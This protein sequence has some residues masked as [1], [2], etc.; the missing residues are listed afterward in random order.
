M[1]VIGAP[2]GGMAAGVAVPTLAK[3]KSEKHG[4]CRHDLIKG[5]RDLRF[6]LNQLLKSA[7]DWCIGLLKNI[8]KTY[9]QF[10]FFFG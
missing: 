5:L 9:K 1:H 2:K 10:L 6:S 7:D 3:A 4:F 8:N